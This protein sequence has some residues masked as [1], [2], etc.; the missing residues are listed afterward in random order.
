M[1]PILGK[2]SWLHLGKKMWTTR[3]A[4]QGKIES[5]AVKQKLKREVQMSW[6]RIKNLK[7]LVLLGV[8]FC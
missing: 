3:E 8:K 1:R 7:K 4:L 6:Q 5:D 2:E